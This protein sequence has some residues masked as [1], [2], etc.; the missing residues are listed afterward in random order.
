MFSSRGFCVVIV[1]SG[2]VRTNSD[3]LMFNVLS[4]FF[5]KLG[6]HTN[7]PAFF[8]SYVLMLIV[9]EWMFKFMGVTTLIRRLHPQQWAAW[10]CKLWLQF[11]VR[12]SKL[13]SEALS[14][15]ESLGCSKCCFP[16]WLSHASLKNANRHLWLSR[17]SSLISASTILTFIMTWPSSRRIFRYLNHFNSYNIIIFPQLFFNNKNIWW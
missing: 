7:T 3:L 13:W 17:S 10:E 5:G 8:S 4:H 1:L 12:N 14:E 16:P 6:L 9:G 11:V 15:V 2:H